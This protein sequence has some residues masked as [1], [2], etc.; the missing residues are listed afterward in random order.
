MSFLV[1]YFS[2]WGL[3]SGL[4]VPL[5]RL[6]FSASFLFCLHAVVLLMDAP[7]RVLQHVGERRCGSG[8][9]RLPSAQAVVGSPP[10]PVPY[11]CSCSEGDSWA[12]CCGRAGLSVARVSR[13]P[14]MTVWRFRG[15]FLQGRAMVL[16]CH[17]AGICGRSW[18]NWSGW[19]QDDKKVIKFPVAELC[20]PAHPKTGFFLL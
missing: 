17:L 10:S 2:L 4:A 6:L 16:H 14:R 5:P 18:F 20:W 9:R 7:E 19:W 1:L 8:W 3:I 13:A 12:H 11:L 15:T